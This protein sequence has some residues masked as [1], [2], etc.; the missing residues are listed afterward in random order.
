MFGPRG[1]LKFRPG[2]LRL[3]RFSPISF[4]GGQ[5][6]FPVLNQSLRNV[7]SYI[8]NRLRTS[9]QYSEEWA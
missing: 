2:D 8:E 9:T 3:S 4:G 6:N 5:I 1:V 7:H